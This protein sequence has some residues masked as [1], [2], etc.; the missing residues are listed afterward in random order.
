MD[1]GTMVMDLGQA[2]GMLQDAMIETFLFAPDK[3]GT[4]DYRT[5]RPGTSR[6]S[7]S[8]APP[9][10]GAAQPRNPAVP[11]SGAPGDAGVHRRTIRRKNIRAIGGEGWIVFRLD[12]GR[13]G[14]L[15]GFPYFTR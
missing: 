8:E 6:R 1:K 7:V 11:V 10:A 14:D 3:D 12:A 15:Q 13:P 5:S 4:R 2:Q 9:N